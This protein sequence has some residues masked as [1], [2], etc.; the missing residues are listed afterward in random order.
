MCGK[1]D[2]QSMYECGKSWEGFAGVRGCEVESEFP[3]CGGMP[4]TS[5]CAS[6]CHATL[7]ILSMTTSGRPSHQES[8]H[9]SNF[10]HSITKT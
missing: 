9:D 4:Q 3:G 10:G 6:V 2:M 7:L 8:G 1:Q 5:N